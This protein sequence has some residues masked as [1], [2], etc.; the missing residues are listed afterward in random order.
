[1]IQS[2]QLFFSIWCNNKT[3]VDLSFHRMNNPFIIALSNGP[4]KQFK[5]IFEEISMYFSLKL[6][7]L[8]ILP[9]LKMYLT[10]F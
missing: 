5:M 10:P 1:M 3:F 6:W 7:H 9:V 8:E 4:W 2:L